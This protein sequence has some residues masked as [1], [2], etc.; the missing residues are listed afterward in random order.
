MV[1]NLLS[2]VLGPIIAIFTVSRFRAKLNSRDASLLYVSFFIA[3]ICVVPALI[4]KNTAAELGFDEKI[5][6]LFGKMGY[7][8]FTGFVDELNKYIVIVAYAYRRKEF[9]E[10]LA[11]MLVTVMIAMGFVTVD[12]VW[13]IIEADKYSETWRMLTAIPVSLCFALIM[14]F[15]SGLS[16]YGL[17]ADD[18]SSFGL[19]V[20][21]LLTATFFHAFYNFF[22]FMEEYRSL[23]GLIV[24][25]TLLMLIQVGANC[26]RGFRLHKRLIY[27]R[28]KRSKS[29]SSI[30]F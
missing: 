24:V 19:R 18:L 10:P 6:S 29:G 16:K 25:A 27:S 4:I 11:G 5:N 30:D 7:A 14:G 23:V 28:K 15:Y 20:R 2:V 9:D 3:M 12:N 26:I 8:A 17:D 1:L 22:L 21:G 13:H